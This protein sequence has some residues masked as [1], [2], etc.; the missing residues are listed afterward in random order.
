[1]NRGVA[2]VVLAVLL[3][4]AQSACADV[5]PPKRTG[6]DIPDAVRNAVDAAVQKVY[7]AL[8]RI[9]VVSV[10]YEG[11]REVKREGSGSGAIISADGYVIT[12]HHVAGKVRRVRCTL[13]NREEL[14][15]TVIGTDPLA[16]IA[17][18]KLN[19]NGRDRSK[20]LPV[21]TFGDSNTLRVGDR[22]LAMGSPMA[23]SQSV[24][25][26]IVS[27]VRMTFPELFTFTFKLDGEE[28]GSLV[29]WIGH[30]AQIFPGNSGGPLVNLKG[31]IVGINEIGIGLGGA[32]PGNLARDVAEELIRSAEVKRSWLGLSV[33]PLLKSG[34]ADRGVLVGEVVPGSPAAKAG[35]QPGDILVS[36]NDK[37]FTIRH[38]EQLPE[39]NRLVLG[40]P[41]GTTV[42]IVYL[43]DGKEQRASATTVARGTAL[44][45]EAELKNWGI[46]VQDLTLLA[47]KE[48][49][50]EPYSGVLVTSVRP[51]AASAEAKPAL[52]D[53]DIIVEVAGKPVKTMHELIARSDEL[54]HG[55][56]HPVPALIGFERRSQRFLTVVKLG[57]RETPDR[58]AEASKAWLPVETQV[59]TPDLAEALGLKDKKGVRITEVFADSTAAK[60]GLKVGDILLR[61]DE[62]SIDASQPEDEEI[63]PTLVRKY[64]VGQKVKLD[65]VRDGKPLNLEVELAASPRS[66][67]ELVEHR[68]SQFEFEARDVTFQDRVQHDF[69]KDQKGALITAVDSG[70]WAALARLM[71]DDLVLSVD[72]HPIQKA[73]DLSEQ[74]KRVARTK[75]ER[76]VFF[77]RRGVH[78]MFLELEPAWPAK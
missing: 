19:L 76:V 37:T 16:D 18:V 65:I 55:K 25:L 57:E 3:V 58:S 12:N 10:H 53:R 63:F 50:R 47:A 49:K 59:L 29:T 35:I 9:H 56:G 52:Q 43:R 64:K 8:V 36:Y 41:I 51:G 75:P 6:D 69:A 17:V 7:P 33:Q 2:V 23:L 73:A 68:Y 5:R 13:S 21:A 48:L 77:I 61:F 78:T 74:M 62:E 4:A 14:E 39:F 11:G 44:G 66:T 67:R 1:M 70:G 40:S 46:A 22:V 54:T 28:V 20:P 71:V 60:A 38:R 27:N 45:N 31:E 15:A 30:D 42:S 32:I 24:T 72:G 26:G 34:K